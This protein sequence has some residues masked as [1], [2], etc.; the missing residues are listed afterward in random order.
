MAIGQPLTLTVG[1]EAAKLLDAVL[2]DFNTLSRLKAQG[3]K[4]N[5]AMR[6][7]LTRAVSRFEDELEI[8]VLNGLKTRAADE[9]KLL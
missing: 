5:P 8:V 1:R 3:Y 9:R 4:L 6:A 7:R 2:F